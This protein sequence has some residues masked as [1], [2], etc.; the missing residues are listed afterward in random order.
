MDAAL[1]VRNSMEAVAALMET[2]TADA[3]IGISN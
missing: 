2:A 3:P 1:T